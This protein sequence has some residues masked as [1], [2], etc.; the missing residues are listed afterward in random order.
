M[1][2]YALNDPL[3]PAMN[4]NEIGKPLT[5]PVPVGSKVRILAPATGAED[6]TKR[7]VGTV[8]T[9]L[10]LTDDGRI[11]HVGPFNPPANGR[12]GWLYEWD[13]LALVELAPPDEPGWYKVEVWCD[14]DYH[15]T[16]VAIIYADSA[17]KALA[18]GG[19]PPNDSKDDQSPKATRIVIPANP[20]AGTTISLY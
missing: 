14:D 4:P 9:V 7:L 16:A 2:R 19:Y 15:L 5:G 18:S 17:A 20:T 13:A 3:T 6:L 1:T 11:L 12:A 8:G 10:E